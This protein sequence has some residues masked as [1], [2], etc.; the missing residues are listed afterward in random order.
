MVDKVFLTEARRN[1]LNHYDAADSNHR[2]HKSRVVDRAK[3]ALNELIW[4]AANPEIE[5]ADVFEEEQMRAL[6]TVLL[7]GSGGF[8][9]EPTDDTPGEHIAT[10][11]DPDYRN[12]LY[13]AVSNALLHVERNTDP[14]DIYEMY[15]ERAATLREL[16]ANEENSSE[17]DEAE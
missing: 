14:T 11:P 5:N 16:R 15:G 1:A 12:S 10:E 13:V 7:A 8:V 17:D 4:V 9:E 3:V 6:L 2:A